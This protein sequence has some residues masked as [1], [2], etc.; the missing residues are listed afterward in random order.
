M[1]I[2]GWT[3]YPFPLANGTL[4]WVNLPGPLTHDDA[5][6]MIEMLRLLVIETPSPSNEEETCSN[7]D[8]LTG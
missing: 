3:F 2:P 7:P 6:R 4:A 5:E 8:S 1:S